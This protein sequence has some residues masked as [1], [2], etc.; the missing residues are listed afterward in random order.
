M[1]NAMDDRQVTALFI[2]EVRALLRVVRRH[3]DTLSRPGAT[4]QHTIAIHELGQLITA[5]AEICSGF[6]AEDCARLAQT[7][8]AIYTVEDAVTVAQQTNSSILATAADI[9]TYIEVRLEVM[10]AHARVLSPNEAERIAM[11]RLLSALH[12]ASVS[13]EGYGGAHGA[14]FGATPPPFV[15]RPRGLAAP[16]DEPGGYEPGATRP[17]SLARA[18]QSPADDPFVGVEDKPVAGSAD[19]SADASHNGNQVSAHAS[20][21]AGA[22]ALTQMPD[23]EVLAALGAEASSDLVAN[24]ATEHEAATLGLTGPLL[25]SLSEDERAV[26]HAFR[27]SKLSPTAY[28]AS[29][30]ALP[31]P[32]TGPLLEPSPDDLGVDAATHARLEDLD[33]IPPELQRIFINE[34]VEDLFDLRDALVRLEQDPNNRSILTEIG[35]IAHKIRGSAGTMGFTVLEAVAYCFED[36]LGVVRTHQLGAAGAAALGRAVNLIQIAHEAARDDREP[37]PTLESIARVQLDDLRAYAQGSV[38]PTTATPSTPAAPPR[39]L[40]SEAGS[41]ALGA[42][43]ESHSRAPRASGE[44]ASVLRLEVHRLDGLMAQV[45]ALALNRSSLARAR[46]EISKLHAELEHALSRLAKLSDE[47]IDLHPLVRYPNAPQQQSRLLQV[48]LGLRFFGRDHADE[49]N[50]PHTAEFDRNQEQLAEF[51]HTVRAL[52]EVVADITT[53]GR[54]LRSSLTHLG[55]VSE[56][57]A[58]VTNQMQQDVMNIRLVPLSNLEPRLQLEVRR[59]APELGKRIN[60]IMRG[61]LTEIDRNIID[62]LDEPLLQLVRNAIVHGIEPREERLANGKSEVGTILLH[63][64]HVGG[65]AVIEVGDDGRGVNPHALIGVAVSRDLID[66]ETSRRLT[67]ADAL[68]LMFLPGLTTEETPQAIGGRGLGLNEVRTRI[69][70]VKG[71]ISVRSEPGMGSIFR[72]HVPISLS[73]VNALH[74]RA[75]DQGYAIPFSSVQRTIAFA[76]SEMRTVEAS[77]AHAQ[78]SPGA[79]SEVH[80]NRRIRLDQALAHGGMAHTQPVAPSPAST[81]ESTDGGAGLPDALSTSADEVP[82][83]ALAELLGY[84]QPRREHYH[85]LVLTVGRQQVAVLIDQVLDPQ[86]VVVQALPRHLRRRAVRGATVTVHGELLLLLDL[87]ELVADALDGV[88]PRPRPRPL[89]ATQAPLSSVPRVLLVDDS[90]SIR[91]AL[92]PALSRAGFE[93]QTA[94]DGIEALELLLANPP[95]AMVLDIEMPRLT[96]LELLS[97]VR[98]TPRLDAV[99]VVMLSSRSSAMFQEQALALGAQAYLIKPCPQETLVETIRAMLVAAVPVQ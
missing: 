31:V 44:S 83:F 21:H 99:R 54:S 23:A 95:Q 14:P 2:D 16:R 11:T 81:D 66:G 6:H 38:A 67:A 35:R 60:F 34:T 45:N 53:A 25:A 27:A 26:L 5:I 80:P 87:Q 84:E 20:N 28:D 15:G 3:L 47:I 32:A 76:A 9:V 39:M 68:D 71:R 29:P 40:P 7:L 56:E 13:T 30:E 77:L 8:A 91:R 49:H 37:P 90:V 48:P 74:I 12:D 42:K 24:A 59:L 61:Q 82:V 70:R 63:A 97:I 33:F 93:V 43:D 94:R 22:H 41:G 18:D 17:T 62:A 50:S 55:Q 51:D 72:I 75:G 79:A 96:G 19:A 1:N 58:S 52:S 85:A 88:K 89:L 4:E 69:E 98:G 78:S 64:Y 46:L 92:E 57:Q 86:E 10:A 65:E 73:V 36:M